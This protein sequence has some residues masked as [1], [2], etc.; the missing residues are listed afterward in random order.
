MTTTPISWPLRLWLGV[1]VLFGL[2]AVLAIGFF[3][4][5]SS[6][7]FAWTIQ[8]VVMA[9]VLGGFYFVSAPLFILPLLAK[10]WEMIRAM[11]LPTALF[12]LLQL[13]ATFLHWDKFSVGT[14]PF[15]IWFAS[16]LLPPPIFISAYL[17]QQR[18][19]ATLPLPDDQS[20]PSWLLK[21][22][23]TI[24]AT[25]ALL[26]T[27]FF[28]FP[29]TIIPHFAWQLTPLTTRSLSAWLVMLG[30]LLL[31]LARE[32]DRTRSVLTTPILIFTLPILVVQ[33]LRFSSQVDWSNPV[34]WLGFT[35][36]AI[37]SGCGIYLAQGSWR[38]ALK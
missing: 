33:M 20:L 10:R 21:I 3:P 35:L 22:M 7:N 15:Y 24:G 34:L 6:T 8:P 4:N 25:L 16:Y 19:A 17:W 14:L 2:G 31:N 1:E 32:N 5:Q 11:I 28:I 13:I 30:F 9:A 12:C 18:R 36:L 37:I 26:A 23:K 27:I 38:Q 29:T